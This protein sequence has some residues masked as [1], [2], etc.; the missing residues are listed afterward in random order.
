MNEEKV[1]R[2]IELQQR[3]NKEID[4]YGQTTEQTIDELMWIID[5]MTPEEE[6]AM[7]NWYPN[8]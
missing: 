2:A 1:H 6:T 5:T 4:T 8:I 7:L 3:A